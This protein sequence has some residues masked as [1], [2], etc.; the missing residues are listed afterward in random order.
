M[1]RAKFISI[2]PLLFSLTACTSTYSI[3]DGGYIAAPQEKE[4][5][6]VIDTKTTNL[7]KYKETLFFRTN[8]KI[9]SYRDVLIKK[10][11]GTNDFKQVYFKRDT[12]NRI[13]RYVDLNVILRKVSYADY[14]IVFTARKN[15]SDDILFLYKDRTS[16]G[17]NQFYGVSVNDN[18]VSELI[19]PAIATF[20]GWVKLNDSKIS[21]SSQ[22][23]NK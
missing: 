1:I 21:A 11:R 6:K 7:S 18:I 17:L 19:E 22:I 8:V 3:K 2:I 9:S 20:S 15:N 14:E 13:N 4:F 10:L 23:K 12:D 16:L 5:K